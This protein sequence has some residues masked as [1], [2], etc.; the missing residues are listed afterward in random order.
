M[1]RAL[2]GGDTAAFQTRFAVSVSLLLSGFFLRGIRRM[3]LGM[4][5]DACVACLEWESEVGGLKRRM[6]RRRGTKGLRMDGGELQA[7][8]GLDEAVDLG[9]RE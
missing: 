7:R 9:R 5:G 8:H 4:R 2:E 1:E 3:R 6:C